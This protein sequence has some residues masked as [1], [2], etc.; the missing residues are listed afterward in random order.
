MRPLRII[1]GILIFANT[2]FAEHTPLDLAQ[3]L[4]NER[5][6]VLASTNSDSEEMRVM[7]ARLEESAEGIKERKLVVYRVTNNEELARK[8]KLSAPFNLVLIGKD[9]T[10]KFRSSKPVEVEII[11]QTIDAMPMRQREIR[12]QK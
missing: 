10:E 1:F 3:H 11:F 5:V 8:L 7:V 4:W 6:L 2:V 12:E 9:G